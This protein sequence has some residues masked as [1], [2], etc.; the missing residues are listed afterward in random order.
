M[1]TAH[2]NSPA[3]PGR[4]EFVLLISSIM[5]LVA[6]AI[7]SMLPALPMIG[8]SMA[9]VD[10]ADW[11]MVIT[12]FL[13]GFGV[14]LLFVGTLSDR[15]GRRGLMLASLV[16]Y[17][18]SS[19]AAALAPSFELLLVARAVQG[20]AAAGGQVLVR[21]L[22][23]DLFEG[24]EMARIMSL[25]GMLFMVGPIIAPFMGQA[26]LQVAPWRW[27][28]VV[29]AGLGVAT[30][31][32][33]ALRLA[34]TLPPERRTPIRLDTIHANARIVLTDRLSVGYTLAQ[35]ATAS[36]LFGFL[37][38]VQAIFDRGFGRADFLPTGFAIMA[39][40]MMGASLLNAT[41]VR[42][43]GM[44]RIGHWAL[45][46]FTA[47]AAIHA[48]YAWSGRE[49][50]ISFVVLQMAMMLAFPLVG[51]NFQAM[52]MERMGA[53]AGTASSIQGF[54]INLVSTITGALIGRAFDGTTVPLYL[55]FTICG[56]LALLAVFVTEGGQ[57]FVARNA[58]SGE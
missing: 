45:I 9:V 52:S 38:S 5:M 26:V 2:T 14:S 3:S 48:L 42:R 27:I 57:L 51:G 6:F 40:G 36:A 43:Y 29:L 4:T 10:P 49:T 17:A 16:G 7:D 20:M 8:A 11:P 53:V 54:F 30:W 41:I 44:R 55:A 58:P 56:L 15:Y 13:G 50:L 24:R 12:A 23:R 33:C 21:A 37:T 47:V 32:W 31:I 19:L 39:T 18:V 28:F 35:A 25:A 22:V 34:E 46:V 1:P